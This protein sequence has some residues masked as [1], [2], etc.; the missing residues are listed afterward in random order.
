MHGDHIEREDESRSRLL[1]P[2]SRCRIYYLDVASAAGEKYVKWQ[3][4][5]AAYRYAEWHL[6]PFSTEVQLQASVRRMSG[7]WRAAAPS[8]ADVVFAAAN[9]SLMCVAGKAYSARSLWQHG[10]TPSAL[11]LDTTNASRRPPPMTVVSLQYRQGCMLPWTVGSLQPGLVLLDQIAADRPLSRAKHR[12]PLAL[13]VPFVISSPHWLTTGCVAPQPQGRRWRDRPLLFFGGHVPKLY[14]NPLRYR[15]WKRL[16]SDPRASLQSRTIMCTVSAFRICQALELWR[17][18]SVHGTTGSRPLTNSSFLHTFC[19]KSCARTQ[20]IGIAGGPGVMGQAVDS[21]SDA[22][23][24]DATATQAARRNAAARWGRMDSCLGSWQLTPKRA[25]A[26]LSSMCTP[27]AEVDFGAEETSMRSAAERSGSR[28]QFLQAAARH[29]FCLVA[30][31][32]PGGTSK[33]A[34]TIALGGAGGCIPVF[35]LYSARSERRPLDS[36]FARDYPF[37]RWLDYCTIAVFVTAHAALH[38]MTRVLDYLDGISEEEGR[39]KLAALRQVRPA[40]VHRRASS[41][42]RPSAAEYSL[43]EACF[44]AKQ[45]RR[46]TMHE[47]KSE[48]LNA[49]AG[50]VHARCTLA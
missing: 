13:V 47:S 20:G 33:V 19:H 15:L 28:E 43:S 3:R 16:R 37:T 48:R 27:Y 35:V 40:F 49:L 34:E 31:G 46:A 18:R 38:N 39:A 45:A 14:V 12:A 36:D 42:S 25:V 22:A 30:Q 41:I 7:A 23:V 4:G 26:R 6:D 8:R 1:P 29:R 50:G 5:L 2:L 11:E 24:G 21:G 32:D 44:V 17:E 9:L 10:M